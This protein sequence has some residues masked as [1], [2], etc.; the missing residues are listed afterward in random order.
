MDQWSEVAVAGA[1]HERGDVVPLEG[2]LQGVDGHLDVGGVLARG[3]HALR[4]VDELDVRSGEHP[5]VLVEVRPVGVRPTHHHPPPLGERVGDRPQVERHAAEVVARTERQVLVVK[6]QGDALFLIHAGQ[7]TPAAGVGE[8]PGAHRSSG[9][10]LRPQYRHDLG[11][12]AA[13]FIP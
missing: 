10:W 5:A 2:Q 8:Q 9:P 3:A 1:E 4:Y 7:R 11:P 13:V 12:Q 6:E